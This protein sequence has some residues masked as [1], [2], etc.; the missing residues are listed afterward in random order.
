ME[1]LIACNSDPVHVAKVHAAFTIGWTMYRIRLSLGSNQAAKPST[2]M[3]S[4][5]ELPT[6][7]WVRFQLDYLTGPL[8]VLGSPLTA[9]PIGQSQALTFFA[10]AQ[11]W[12]DDRDAAVVN[13]DRLYQALLEKLTT[14]DASLGSALVLGRWLAATCYDPRD[15]PSVQAAFVRQKLSKIQSV[16]KDV[17]DKLPDDV[18]VTVSM[19]LDRWAAWVQVYLRPRAPANS[20]LAEGDQVQAHAEVTAL[21]PL[22]DT[23]QNQGEHWRAL[24]AGEKDPRSLLTPEAN[25]GAVEATAQRV[26]NIAWRTVCQF[27][28]PIVVILGLGAGAVVAFDFGGVGHGEGVEQP[29]LGRRRRRCD[30]GDGE[31]RRGVH[32]QQR[33]GRYHQDERHRRHGLRRHLAA[34]DTP[35]LVAS[36]DALE[37]PD[38][39]ARSAAQRGP[40]RFAVKQTPKTTFERRKIGI[41]SHRIG[42]DWRDRTRRL[43]ASGRPSHATR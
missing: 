10:F 27:A 31:A 12:R 21:C 18:A 24:L 29:R 16:L 20:A 37:P 26:G 40:D 30:R 38:A 35:R 15:T 23:L 9:P 3:P 32:R 25:A 11:H 39:A 5:S 2:S 34:R 41:S 1:L 8:Q 6:E 13:A 14:A 42:L 19:S 33:R 7:S 4:I 17:A 28:I 22:L 36:S 43:G